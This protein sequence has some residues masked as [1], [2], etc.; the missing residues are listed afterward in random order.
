MKKVFILSCE[1]VNNGGGIYCYELLENKFCNNGYFPCDRPMYAIYK[2]DR[3]HVV[4][5][6]AC[7]KNSGYFYIKKNFT[8]PSN[9]MDTQ[10]VVACHLD[11]ALGNNYIVNYLSG[12]VVKNC[13]KVVWHF[14]KG[15]NQNRQ[16]A[17]HTH[18]CGVLEDKYLIVTDLGIDTISVYDLDLNL[19]SQ[20]N[21]P[22]GYG[23]RHLVTAKEGKTIYSVNELVPSVSI[24]DF[25]QGE[26]VYK[27]T[28]NLE[29]ENKKATGCAIRL[30]NNGEYL[31]L[32]LREENCIVVLKI[33]KTELNVVQKFSCGGESP[34]DIQII[35]DKYLISCNEKSDN[36]VLFGLKEGLIDKVLHEEKISKPLCCVYA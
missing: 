3:M 17:P 12:N 21:V 30:S 34:R 14:G 9:V 1:T 8:L 15:K 35:E 10:G 24:F 28:V 25:C 27:K 19:I 33:D 11:V 16:D 22:L 4:L 29:F 26:I 36:I 20:A 23:V 2:N 5:R 7:G 6:Q 31:Y 13:N 18:Y 32:S